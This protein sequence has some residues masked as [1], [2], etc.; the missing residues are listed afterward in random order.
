[1]AWA[2]T[3]PLRLGIATS[4]TLE[5]WG[6]GIRFVDEWSYFD[7]DEP[8]LRECTMRRFDS[9]RRIQW[10]VHYRLNAPDSGE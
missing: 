6:P 4:R 3:R 7:E 10:T 9:L 5:E 2:Q 1:M 8:R